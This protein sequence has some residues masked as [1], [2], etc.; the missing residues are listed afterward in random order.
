MEVGDLLEV[1]IDGQPH[2]VKILEIE[3]DEN[4]NIIGYTM[5]NN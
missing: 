5:I 1:W 4:G 2:T 3:K